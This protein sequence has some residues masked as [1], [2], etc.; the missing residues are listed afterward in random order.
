MRARAHTQTNTQTNNIHTH[1]QN[2]RSTA[3]STFLPRSSTLIL[4]LHSQLLMRAETVYIA[5]SSMVA[6]SCN[7]A[8]HLMVLITSAALLLCSP[9]AGT[10]PIVTSSLTVCSPFLSLSCAKLSLRASAPSYG[11]AASR[12]RS[13][14][15]WHRCHLLSLTSLIYL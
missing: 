1:T 4:S 14:L 3:A 15:R 13:F 2:H 10:R 6:D 11:A 12:I 7:P 9:A 8:S 5:A